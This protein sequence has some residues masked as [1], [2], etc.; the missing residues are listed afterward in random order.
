ME[1]DSTEVIPEDAIVH[2]KVCDKCKG[3]FRTAH[4]NRSL[5]ASCED[6]YLL[7]IAEESYHPFSWQD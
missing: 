5:C 1:I 3:V 4:D 2:V 7:D 6:E